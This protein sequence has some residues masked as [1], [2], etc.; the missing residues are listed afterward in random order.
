M[1]KFQIPIQ[2]AITVKSWQCEAR[3]PL[4]FLLKNKNVNDLH[5]CRLEL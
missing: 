2:S 1:R 5:Q 3:C 4:H